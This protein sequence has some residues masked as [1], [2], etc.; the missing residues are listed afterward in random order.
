MSG[1][2]PT[3]PTST[4]P[5]V[6]ASYSN[7]DADATRRVAEQQRHITD[8]QKTQLEA[9]KSMAEIA[10]VMTGQYAETMTKLAMI[11]E[12]YQK[13]RVGGELHNQQM[14]MDQDYRKQANED[15]EKQLRLVGS[16]FTRWKDVYAEHEKSIAEGN[17]M[18]MKQNLII[19]KTV[20]ETALGLTNIEG[21][22]KAILSAV[23]FGGLL[24]FLL[25]GVGAEEQWKANTNKVVNEFARFGDDSGP[26]KESL[27]N[28][29]K[30][31]EIW[32]PNATQ[33]LVAV[34]R[35]FAEAG[36]KIDS[37]W[38]EKKL[39]SSLATMG[40]T[41]GEVSLKFDYLQKQA[42]GWTASLLKIAHREMGDNVNRAAE[43]LFA[44]SD[45]AV[46]AGQDSVTF[47]SRV[48][49]TGEAMKLYGLSVDTI[50]E[51]TLR[52]TN[53]NQKA[54]GMGGSAE[55][56]AY[57]GTLAAFQMQGIAG[58][59]DMPEGPAAFFGKYV[60]ARMMAKHPEWAKDLKEKA[61]DVAE[62][63]NTPMG[64]AKLVQNMG[65]LKAHRGDEFFA[66]LLQ[67]V[68][69]KVKEMNLGAG[70]GEKFLESVG[71]TKGYM[72]AHG[73][74]KLGSSIADTANM[75]PEQRDLIKQ[76]KEIPKSE[77]SQLLQGLK[78]IE[79]GIMDIANGVL[80]MMLMTLISI[81]LG[82]KVL[83][84][85]FANKGN[86]QNSTAA[87]M[88]AMEG[89]GK[90]GSLIGNGAIKVG[91]GLG[92]VLTSGPMGDAVSLTQLAFG[93]KPQ[94][95]TKEGYALEEIE[96]EV[97]L[98]VLPPGMDQNKYKKTLQ[99]VLSRAAAGKSMNP[100]KEDSA[101][102]AAGAA[103][104]LDTGGFQAF[105]KSLKDL[106]DAQRAA[107]E[108]FNQTHPGLKASY[109]KT[110]DVLTIVVR[111]VPVEQPS[112]QQNA[113]GAA[114]SGGSNNKVPAQGKA[115]PPKQK[116]EPGHSGPKHDFGPYTQ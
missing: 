82:I 20:D 21:A 45:A 60:I 5:G 23:P 114:A 2:N 97:M 109:V 77:V 3:D 57:A 13:L 17:D 44:Y 91:H 94:P 40:G 36:I 62:L 18:A 1:N 84:D 24:T 30:A 73:L 87:F 81:A 55:H 42:P 39:S 51:Q 96:R 8:E 59:K 106:P 32:N 98:R 112:A 64:V 41:L 47:I 56:K 100:D 74:L 86:L 7:T 103:Y 76:G 15:L 111:Q 105:V 102:D 49:Q 72:A 50:A 83:F 110:G 9:M 34:S 68:A 108:S 65:L 54:F 75:T 16:I 95:G 63:L 71:I 70:F 4:N 89:I 25:H 31:M 93:M 113:S 85:W 29:I 14:R 19:R 88:G 48:M 12:T 6:S 92:D 28:Q 37:V 46:R 11:T 107:V 101:L 22:F 26:Y 61:P 67:V 90:Y 80:G 27:K 69:E 58:V 99:E 79:Q 38:G 116:S 43:A 52:L 10:K 53:I 104:R 78:G 115:P 66:T 35:Q 33:D